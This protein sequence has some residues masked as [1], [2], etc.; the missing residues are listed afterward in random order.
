MKNL[1]I[2]IKVIIVL[3]FLGVAMSGSLI[4]AGIAGILSAWF[5]LVENKI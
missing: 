4:I 2:A 1:K 5:F 3:S